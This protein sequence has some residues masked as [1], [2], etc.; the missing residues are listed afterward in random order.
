MNPK[1][2]A[3]LQA[4]VLLLAGF[5]V[6][7]PALH[8]PFVSDDSVEIT[9]NV[10][11]RSW[12]GLGRIWQGKD[13][14]DYFPLKS[15]VQWAEWHLWSDR[16][17]GYHLVSLGLHLFSALLFWGLLRKLGLRWG[18]IG[19]L[20][21]ALHPLAVE[22]VAW[23]SEL[24]NTLSLPWLLL[25]FGAYVNWDD[26]QSGRL[27]A[28]GLAVRAPYGAALFC[29]LLAL[30]AKSSVVMFPA[31]LLLYVW[32]KRGRIGRRD[33]LASV[34]FAALA[35]V[36]GGATI[37]FQRD[38]AIRGVDLH[39]GG[40]AS[41]AA[42]AGIMAV[43]YWA[44]SVVPVALAFIYPRWT[45]LP[46]RWVQCLPGLAG[47]A[48]LIW[49]WARRDRSGG[50]RG[51]GFGLGWFALNLVPVLGLVPMAYLRIAWTADHFAY[52]S[53]LG[54][55]AL[56]AAGLE[57]ARLPLLLAALAVC[58]GLAWESHRHA[59]DFEGEEALWSATLRANPRTGTAYN[60]LG[61]L[62]LKQHRPADAAGEFRRAIELDPTY[63]EPR[64]NLGQALQLQ[65]DFP[66]AIAQYQAALGLSAAYDQ[67]AYDL[68]Q[69]YFA[70][71]RFPEAA[72][73]YRQSLFYQPDFSEAWNNLGAALSRLGRFDE[74][75]PAYRAALQLQPN[76][77]EAETN[78][79]LAFAKTGRMSEAIAHFEAALRLNPGY[80]DA[81]HNLQS[82]LRLLPTSP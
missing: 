32:W 9:D 60:N 64:R 2:R 36:L 70:Q 12:A 11:L 13:S 30:L 74:A 44:K 18:W 7:A 16:P 27:G 35:L 15:T 80:P 29:F 82:A 61:V 75:I 28:P 77:P 78:L 79:G 42:G 69:I 46:F 81:R 33:L 31:L 59:A 40:A 19:G 4:V 23:I 58:L 54:V 52:V 55:I 62:R 48:V 49:L 6:Y 66:G 20:L 53:L 41:R 63:P 3:V 24:K 17:L 8:G 56:A 50:A 34:P 43:F 47:G 5:W 76:Y 14:T 51:L 25:A 38:R 68:G 39:L 67:A 45:L 26:R 57:R 22:S 65:G 72:A 73:A 1:L 21:F 37:V 10:D 71:H